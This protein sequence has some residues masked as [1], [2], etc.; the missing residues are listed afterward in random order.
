MSRHRKLDISSSTRSS[1]TKSSRSDTRDRNCTESISVRGSDL[2][3]STI[4]AISRIC[5][6]CDNKPKPCKSGCNIKHVSSGYLVGS[7]RDEPCYPPTRYDPGVSYFPS[8]VTP[9]SNLV[10]LYSGCTGSVEFR[11]RRKNKTVTLQWEPFTGS[12]AAAGIAYLT[13]AQSI[14]NTPP[15]LISVPIYI[16]YKGVGRVTHIEIDPSARTGNIRFYLNTDGS[17]TGTAVG[18]T[19][20]IYGGAITWIVD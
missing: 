17:T 19:I 4:D 5:D 18:D 14:C 20:K 16:E 1:N 11:M 8:V 15:Y 3:S 13:V 9:L 2:S 10:P 12:L 6:D 7:T